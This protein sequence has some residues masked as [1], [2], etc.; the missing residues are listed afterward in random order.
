M[1]EG[2]KEITA[3]D[4]KALRGALPEAATLSYSCTDGVTPNFDLSLQ[5]QVIVAAKQKA[6]IAIVPATDPNL[7]LANMTVGGRKEK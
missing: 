3:K 1:S 7:A 5:G 4:V 6:V 2:P